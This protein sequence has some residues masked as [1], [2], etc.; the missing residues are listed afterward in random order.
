ML[1]TSQDDSN[2]LSRRWAASPSVK[3]VHA[4]A[5]PHQNANTKSVCSPTV[6][7]HQLSH[8]WGVDLSQ[9]QQDAILHLDAFWQVPLQTS[10]LHVS[11]HAL[12]LCI[13]QTL[14]LVMKSS[15]LSWSLRQTAAAARETL[16]GR[17][18]LWSA[19]TGRLSGV[20]RVTAA[21]EV[22]RRGLAAEAISA[23]AVLR[24]SVRH[25]ACATGSRS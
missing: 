2:A 17:Q 24:V 13:R 4:V 14:C 12:Y 23:G 5:S 3:R 8:C 15:S 20:L 19:P 7:E 11:P 22:C 21:A 6:C 25:V 9:P 1:Q 10:H 18:S 16:C